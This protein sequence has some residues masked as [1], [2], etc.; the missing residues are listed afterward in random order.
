MSE[1]PKGWIETEIGNLAQVVAG[2]TPKSGDYL[3][4]AEPG[5]GIAWLTPAD[6]SGYKQKGITNGR[7]DLS[8]KGL[9]S[10]SAKL[11]PKGTV[12][13]S[14]R[15]PI[16]YVVIAENEICTNQGFKSFVFTEH[17][18]STY[19]YYYLKSIR[20]LAES[21]GTGTTFKELS[22]AVA[23]KLPFRL[24]PLNEQIRIAYK[25][26]SI[27]AKV[28]QAQ[29]RLEKI[30]AILKRFR[31]SILAAATS[32]E[33]TKEWREAEGVERRLNKYTVAQIAKDE[34]Y[35]LGIGPFGSNLKVVD[36]RSEGHP[37]VFVR[38][39]RARKFG[40]GDTKYVDNDKFTELAAHRAKPG[41]LLITK[42]GDPPG[43]VAIYPETSPEAVI[44][45]DCIKLDVNRQ[46]VNKKF[47]FYYLQSEHFQSQMK[48]ITAGVAQ[49]KVNLKNFKSLEL[50]MPGLAEQEQAVHRI[51]SMFSLA[52]KVDKQYLEAKSRLDRLTQSILAK[53]FRGEL[54]PQD[55]TDDPAGEL[56]DLIKAEL[57]GIKLKTKA[58]PKPKKSTITKD[59]VE[60]LT[61]FE[62]SEPFEEHNQ[63][64]LDVGR[65]DAKDS[66]R[67]HY[68]A[69]ID[70]A[71]SALK[72]AKFTIE[73]FRSVTDF[74]GDYGS[75]KALIMNLLKGIPKLSE[76][77]LEVDSWDDKSGDYVL[78]L[79]EAK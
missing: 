41:D 72:E 26:D 12:L 63:V 59:K 53:A 68:Q 67:I 6:L 18:N 50:L 35:S 43:D 70:K 33:L 45:S 19:A 56:L 36:Y 1:L 13:F 47:T 8:Q 62:S 30:P 20:D 60:Q 55:L 2:G 49:Q 79:Q 37:L 25:L 28:D 74:K 42:M 14:S 17:V 61:F 21:W 48:S 40:G 73:Q 64:D 71:Q 58:V 11:M 16:G 51:E 24:A 29:T 78:R 75:L 66:L 39:I 4:F 10:S 65:G 23:K 32:G 54:V 38:E 7:R 69:E 31:Q 22:G 3:N 15:A 5:V 44:T 77:L 76:P 27:L 34:K 57:V 9:D 46:L 52:E